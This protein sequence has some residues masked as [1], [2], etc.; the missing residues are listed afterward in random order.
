[1]K[2]S[3]LSFCLLTSSV[4]ADSFTVQSLIH[5]AL[6]THPELRYYEAQVDAAKGGKIKA[7]EIKNPD[8]MT[9]V[10]NLARARPN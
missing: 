7:G 6:A 2:I 1:M 8:L 9:G 3:F 4:F 5:K 10:G